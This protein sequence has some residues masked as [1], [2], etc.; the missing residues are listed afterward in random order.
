MKRQLIINPFLFHL[1]KISLLQAFLAVIF[2]GASL[3]RNV[4]AQELLNRKVSLRVETQEIRKVLNKIEKQADIR[5][6]YR[7]RVLPSDHKISLTATNVSLSEILEMITKP[8]RLKYEVVGQQ[9]ILSPEPS[10][11][12]PTGT[13]GRRTV[14]GISSEQTVSGKVSDEKGEGLPGVSI[15]VKGTQQGTITDAQGQYSLSFQ[16]KNPVLIFSFVGYVPQEVSVGNLANIDIILK[17]DTKALEEVVVV[18]YG[19]QSRRNVTGSV[20]KVD[21]KQTQNLPNTNVTQSLRGRVAGVQFTDNGRPGQNGTILIRGPR[22][23]NGGN[24]PLIVVDGIFFN[25][26]LADLNPNDIESME[27]LKDASSAAIYGSRAANGVI[28]ITSK[29]G[30]TEKPTIRINAFS[31]LSDWSYKPKLLSPERYLQKTL[32]NRQQSGLTADPSK[33]RDYLTTSELVNY[34][35][36]I[37]TDPY[38]AISQQGRINSYDLSLS[39]KT[40]STNYFLS[41][42]IADEKGLIYNDNMRR[43]AVRA[44]VENKVTKWLS[45]GL[46]STYI[47]RDLSGKEADL[48][49]AYAATPYG[50]WYYPDGEPTWYVIA[51]DQIP[52]NAMRDAIFTTNEEVY[53][54]LFA[55]FYALIDLPMLKGLSYRFNYSPNYRWQ[56]NYN[57]VRQDKHEPAIN[58]TSASK[59]NREDFDWVMEN[60][61]TY[62]RQ[63]GANH[64]LDITL[65]YGRNHSGFEST[66]ASSS[67]LSSDALS[68]NNLGL[69]EIL[70]NSSTA[71][72][73]D[74]VSSMFRLNYR[75][76]DKYL[77]TGTVRRDGSS[78]FAAN[79][80]Y[81]TFPSVALAWIASEEKFLKNVSFL[82]NLKLRLSYGAVGNQAINPYQSLS[83]SATNRYV[84]G[85]GG[86]SSLGVYPANMANSNLKWET[87]YTG[88]AA[89]DFDLFK[90]RLGGT[91]EFYNM[92]T[93]NLLVQ[94]SL[95][96]M[97]GYNFVL[98]N[99]GATNNKGVEITLNSVNLRKGKFEWSSNIV[100]SRNKN[101]IVHLYHSDTNGDGREDDDLGNRWFIGQSQ[102]VAFDYV[103]DGIYQEGDELPT[104]YKPGFVRLKDLNGDKKIDASDRRVIGQTLQ[105]KYR[106]GVTN[107]F[108]YGDLSMSVFVNAMQG[109]ISNLSTV[110]YSVTGG[111][112]PHRPLNMIDAGWW[113]VENKSNTRPS[114]VYTNPYGHGYYYS[115]NFIRIQDVSLTYDMPKNLINKAKLTNLRLTLS[116]KNLYNFTKWI[117][118]DPE[119]GYTD[120]GSFYPTARSVTMGI[121]LGF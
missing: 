19:T 89:I 67:R 71:Q 16:E 100:F 14:E 44:N 64:A 11:A 110:D 85:D 116:A 70:T 75:F 82:D 30:T 104:G 102:N 55:N 78:V 79:N 73:A 112:Y 21:M 26:S 101:K 107:T 92:N 94:R 48:G 40:N 7:P 37:T 118:P 117:G 58:N 18:G 6:A 13:P 113:N 43:L 49:A 3:A 80:K 12:L 68:W 76:M 51:E 106:W 39:G 8:L 42:S 33:I 57:F 1:M 15:V 93:R 45:I 28:L 83:L 90:G 87:T 119:S 91:F 24:N 25:G 74:G 62:S 31:G 20:S 61:V 65:L 32:D 96:D 17:T 2:T 111:N 105:P 95:P 46:N 60:I 35:A 36:G 77:F 66:T 98:T 97:T 50:T 22:S 34:D 56:H 86:L 121:N 84:Y 114:M 29:K 10:S 47:K 63:F 38:D 59:F 4:S 69:G 5:F 52:Y 120:R 23:L 72:A 115:R 108:R 109:W 41:A 88:N 9:I 99:L 103:F 54:N 53:N 81:A 27:V